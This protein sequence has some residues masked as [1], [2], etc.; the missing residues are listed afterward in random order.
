MKK[1]KVCWALTDTVFN[2][3]L[4]ATP[5]CEEC[6]RN[7]FL[8]QA[9]WYAKQEFKNLALPRVSGQSEQLKAFREW[10]RENLDQKDIVSQTAVDRYLESL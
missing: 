8:Q 10:T 5:I 9:T 1:C 2:I 6:A 4:K 3:N 7:I